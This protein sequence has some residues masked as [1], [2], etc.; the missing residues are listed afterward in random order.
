M[1]ELNKL[2]LISL[3]VR[4]QRLRGD[5]AEPTILEKV[6]YAARLEA[7]R[8]SPPVIV[9]SDISKIQ[10]GLV[11]PYNPEPAYKT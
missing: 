10:L 9:H 4:V 5:D 8:A 3:R 1:P 2:E 6:M 7:G 11:Y